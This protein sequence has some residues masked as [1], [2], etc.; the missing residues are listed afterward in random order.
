MKRSLLI[1][2]MTASF[3]EGADVAH[4]S[5][6]PTIK[7]RLILP[8]DV[9]ELPHIQLKVANQGTGAKCALHALFNGV[10]I[11]QLAQSNSTQ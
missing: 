5:N 8:T 11:A 3:L 2:L 4:I 9:F 10:T 1:L 6:K 7:N